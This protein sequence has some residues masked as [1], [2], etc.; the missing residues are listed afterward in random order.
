MS[1]VPAASTGRFAPPWALSHGDAR[2]LGT[3]ATSLK[4]LAR[5]A[6][7]QYLERLR[8]AFKHLHRP[9]ERRQDEKWSPLL[10]GYARV[11]Q[12]AEREASGL[13]TLLCATVGP[14][15]QP[16]LQV[17][18]SS[19]RR[20]MDQLARG[21]L[22]RALRL[23]PGPADAPAMRACYRFTAQFHRVPPLPFFFC[24]FEEVVPS[25]ECFYP[26]KKI[27]IRRVELISAQELR[28][29]P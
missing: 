25:I 20:E 5:G 19:R 4:A 29:S 10:D 11:N 7:K 27:L 26:T 23:R 21:S 28:R 14:G 2:K 17:R 1:D 8:Q 22:S 15:R 9:F 24:R 18:R 6:T 16:R 12:A 3:V 13:S